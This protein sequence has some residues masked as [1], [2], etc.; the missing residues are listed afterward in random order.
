MNPRTKR[1]ADRNFLWHQSLLHAPGPN[2]EHS[3]PEC[4]Y[5]TAYTA[6]EIEESIIRALTARDIGSRH[7]R[8]RSLS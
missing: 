5:S 1:P 3:N 4:P 6:A 8:K 2:D 7:E